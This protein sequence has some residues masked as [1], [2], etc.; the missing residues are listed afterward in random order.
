MSIADEIY[1]EL[2]RVKSEGRKPTR[3]ALSM[4][5]WWELKD[6]S[7]PLLVMQISSQEPRIYG[8]EIVIGGGDRL[9]VT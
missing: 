8:L 9:T 1:S 4:P 3:V 7:G 2:Q 6:Q 5:A